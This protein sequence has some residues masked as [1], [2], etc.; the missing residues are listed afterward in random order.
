MIIREIRGRKGE[1][2]TY[3]GSM[4]YIPSPNWVVSARTGLYH[5]DV[6]DL[7]IGFPGLIHNF[8]TS[9][10]AAGVAALPAEFQRIPGFFSDVLVG[11]ATAR[12]EYER[13]YGSLDGT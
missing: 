7:G 5:T 9:S 3:S 10:T 1:R 12:D 13:E 2:N 4:D 6:E 8:S 11:G